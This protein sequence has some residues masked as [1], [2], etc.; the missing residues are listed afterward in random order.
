M[1]K[2]LAAVQQE[3]GMS[4]KSL[5]IVT[6]DLQENCYLL[7]RDGEQAAIVFD[8]GDEAE[9]IDRAMKKMRIAPA[10]FLQTHC[11]SD[12]I[13]ALTPLKNLYPGAPLYCPAAEAI[14]LERPTLNLSYFYGVNITGPKPEHLINDGDI[15]KVGSL[16][17]KAIHVPGHSPGGTAFFIE[18]DG[19]KAPHLYCGDILFAGGIGRTDLPGGA[20]EDL[21]IEG[22]REK[23]FTLP[24]ETIV[25]PGHGAETT[26][27]E[28]K[29]NN[30]F[31]GLS[32]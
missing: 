26:I 16:S 20:G 8:P 3:T 28:E 1:G 27:G 15:I 11:H 22:I 5:L 12:H 9:M 19:G 7:W 2:Q 10:A 18:D 30:P 29:E 4:L 31:C 32:V 23:L 14:W 21:L 24:E 17:L 25:H 6:G 13:G